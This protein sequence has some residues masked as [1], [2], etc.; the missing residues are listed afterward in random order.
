MT[1]QHRGASL[2]TSI[3]LVVSG[4]LVLGGCTATKQDLPTIVGSTSTA[5]QDLV[6]VARTYYDC[7][8]NAGIS[9]EF[10]QNQHGDLT[11]V[12]YVGYGWLLHVP[13]FHWRWL[14]GRCG[15][16]GS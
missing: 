14:V 10:Q 9:V 7:M 13:Q 8:S 4:T 16:V 1:R 3:L 2:G 6:A 11:I 5:G 15:H 12:E